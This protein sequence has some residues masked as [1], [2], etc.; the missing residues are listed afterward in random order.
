MM[1]H[2]VSYVLNTDWPAIVEHMFG[3]RFHVGSKL[4]CMFERFPCRVK[5][6]VCVLE[7]ISQPMGILVP[8]SAAHVQ[9]GSNS[10][11]V[12]SMRYT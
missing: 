7:F 6:A 8:G 1:A 12:K 5:T 10:F 11:G 4:L 2:S 9:R 3:E